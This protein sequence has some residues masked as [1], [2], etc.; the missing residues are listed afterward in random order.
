MHFKLLAILLVAIAVFSGCTHTVEVSC[1][2]V[3]FPYT[4]YTYD[5]VINKLEGNYFQYNAQQT[6]KLFNLKLSVP[7]GW[8]FKKSSKNCYK[9]SSNKGR[10]FIFSF[11]DGIPYNDFAQQIHFIGCPDVKS[12]ELLPLKLP[13]DY[14]TDLFHF[15]QD[16]LANNPTLWQAYILWSKTKALKDAVALNH[17]I[18]SNLDAFQKKS[19]PKRSTQILPQSE[20]AIFPNRIKPDYIKISASF[21]DD[22]FFIAFLDMMNILNP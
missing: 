15:T 20:I 18:G 14:Y 17:F 19:N 21:T 6:T 9:F 4:E 11:I 2:P 7:E 22:L 3:L 5:A 13:K 10:T 16:Q 8:T 12:P 1:Y